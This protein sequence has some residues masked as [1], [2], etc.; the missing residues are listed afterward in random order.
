[1]FAVDCRGEVKASSRN[2]G[3]ARAVIKNLQSV[4]D[5]TLVCSASFFTVNEQG[6]KLITF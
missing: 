1:M 2:T 6:V 5:A 3:A 4:F